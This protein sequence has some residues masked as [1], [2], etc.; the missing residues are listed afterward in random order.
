MLEQGDKMEEDTYANMKYFEF[1]F[2]KM[3]RILVSLHSVFQ[4]ISM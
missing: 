1:W 4:I 3:G 2:F